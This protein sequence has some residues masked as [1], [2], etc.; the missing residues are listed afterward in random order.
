[1]LADVARQQ[2]RIGVVAAADAVADDELD[3][4]AFVE[5]LDAGGAG[6]RGEREQRGEGDGGLQR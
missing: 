5:I 3:V 1:M 6:G 2:P 4:A